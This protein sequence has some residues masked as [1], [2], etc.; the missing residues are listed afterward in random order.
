MTKRMLKDQRRQQLLTLAREMVSQQGA[1][2]LT[3]STLAQKAGV[4]KPVTYRHFHTKEGLLSELYR[5]YDTQFIESVKQAKQQQCNSLSALIE[6]VCHGYIDCA[7]RCGSEYESIIAA[8]QGCEAFSA[9]SHDI[10]NHYA[11]FYAELFGEYLPPSA[12]DNK[13]L[14]YAVHG[15]IDEIANAVACGDA[16]K[17]AAVSSLRVIIANI[18]Q[19]ASGINH[20]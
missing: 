3:L 7:L 2:S 6:L 10:R 5:F 14:F 1:G 17:T 16:D 4:T 15:A 19:S 20:G 9:L 18:L 12:Q 8:L 13:L 11:E